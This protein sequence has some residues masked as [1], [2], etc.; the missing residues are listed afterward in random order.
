MI[1][2]G[3]GFN[4]I[5][6]ADYYEYGKK[7]GQVY[8]KFP[9]RLAV[10]T[11]PAGGSYDPAKAQNEFDYDVAFLKYWTALE[12][13]TFKPTDISEALSTNVATLLAFG[14]YDFIKIEDIE[15][16]K[17]LLKKLYDKRSDVV[18]E[19][20]REKVSPLDLSDICKYS[21][22]IVLSLL[23]LR[24]LNYEN[25]EDIKKETDRLY[26]VSSKSV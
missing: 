20:M 11:Y 19:G 12:A 25:L 3:C 24:R 6:A 13:V 21:T 18:H 22:W 4:H 10:S 9:V 7:G 26:S 1:I 5:A 14:G 17:R 16:T 23:N 15:D 8:G 2:D